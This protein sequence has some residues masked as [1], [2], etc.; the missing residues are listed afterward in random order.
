MTCG[1]CLCDGGRGEE[2]SLEM[3]TLDL[4]DPGV[5]NGGAWD[6]LYI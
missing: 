6:S 5:A 1:V 2:S 3:Q 4:R